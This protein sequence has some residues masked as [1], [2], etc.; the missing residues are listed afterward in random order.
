[1]TASCDEKECFLDGSAVKNLPVDAGSVSLGQDGPLEEEMATHSSILTWEIPRTEVPGGL[2]SMG[3]QR[4]WII[5]F[6][7]DILNFAKRIQFDQFC[8]LR[9][10]VKLFLTDDVSWRRT[11]LGEC[12]PDGLVSRKALW[13]G[14]R[15]SV[16]LCEFSWIIKVHYPI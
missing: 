16:V 7:C 3:L 14:H 8:D 15:L 12:S 2:E 11:Y 4:S 9:F 6:T 10:I 5:L 1:M 13:K